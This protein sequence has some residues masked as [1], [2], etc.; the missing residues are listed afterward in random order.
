MKENDLFM[1]E[2]LGYID[3]GL[4]EES[5]K[6]MAKKR[7]P[8]PARA[9]MVAACVCALLVTVAVAAEIAGFDFVKIL[10]NGEESEQGDSYWAGSAGLE[11][12]PLEELSPA[13]QELQEQYKDEEWHVE[14]RYFDSWEEA[15]EYVGREISDNSVLAQNAYTTRLTDEGNWE[16]I[17]AVDV[18]IKYGEIS[19]LNVYAYYD[20]GWP[21]STAD[22]IV[23]TTL[24]IG[25]GPSPITEQSDGYIFGVSFG[26]YMTVEGQEGYLAANG[27]ETVIVSMKNISDEGGAY[28]AHF[29]LRGIRFWVMANYGPEDQETVLAGLKEVLDN[30]Q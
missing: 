14:R 30:F 17:C 15:E 2:A 7:R 19:M 13:F 9:L 28:H 23:E 4:L 8:A 20:M 18:Y 21:W 10:S 3:P 5:E 12:I 16:N 11:Y 27:L 1:Q 22:I 26:E 29:F 24:Y 25:E 6:V